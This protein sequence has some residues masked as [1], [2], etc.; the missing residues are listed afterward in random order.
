MNNDRMRPAIRVWDLPTRLFHWMLVAGIAAAFL[1]EE[2]EAVDWHAR[3][4]YF[5]FSLVVFRLLWGLWG[6][7]HAR[8]VDFVY[9]PSSIRRY[10]SAPWPT[11]GHNPLGS[12]SVLALLG[13]VLA[14]VLT[15]MA[16]RDDIDFEGPLVRHLPDAW[17]SLAGGTHEILQAILLALIGLHLAAIAYYRWMKQDDLLRAMV[18]GDKP[19]IGPESS[20]D[21]CVPG[22][23]GDQEKR[24]E[25]PGVTDGLRTR[26][27]GL[28][29]YLAALSLVL[30][31]LNYLSL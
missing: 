27:L 5:V 31:L 11:L 3:V 24:P 6:T 29:T 25:D 4:G 8:F 20:L 9:R 2:L 30:G 16:N 12:L 19:A 14:Q 7:R 1:T 10:L 13:L 18:T 28:L 26:L 17:V 22:A 23:G 21:G 15:G